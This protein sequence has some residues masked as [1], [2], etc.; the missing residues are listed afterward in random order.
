RA[1]HIVTETR[2]VNEAEQALK[3][4]D[5][6]TFGILM[7]ESGKSSANDYDI[8]H[9]VVEE[10]VAHLRNQDGV[11]GARMMGGGNGGP[12]LVLIKRDAVYS[13]RK[14]LDSYYAKHPIK[15]PDRAFYTCTFG[16]GAHRESI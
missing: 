15:H 11:L 7:T 9:P 14:S 13:V 5:W 3:A 8:S 6:S 2:R 1:R 16:P 12:A 4:E 10:L